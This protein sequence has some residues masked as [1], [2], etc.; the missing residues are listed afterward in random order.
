MYYCLLFCLTAWLVGGVSALFTPLPISWL[1]GFMT[2]EVGGP[3]IKFLPYISKTQLL[4]PRG[5]KIKKIWVKGR[6][7]KSRTTTD[8]FPLSWLLITKSPISYYAISAVVMQKFS[9]TSCCL[10]N[11]AIQPHR[12]IH[13]ACGCIPWFFTQGLLK[14]NSCIRSSSMNVN[15][16]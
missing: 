5:K 14:L 16:L 10:Y 12:G 8:T 7:R 2:L 15:S 9:S 13:S 4:L 11:Q 3:L 6:T 1:C